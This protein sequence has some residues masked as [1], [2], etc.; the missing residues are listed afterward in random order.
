M[1]A[2]IAGDPRFRLPVSP[3]YTAFIA[4]A[5]LALADR[6]RARRPDPR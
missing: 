5:L 2:L 3:F 6:V 1:H 4:V